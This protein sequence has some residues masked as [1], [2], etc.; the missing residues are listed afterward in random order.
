MPTIED[1]TTPTDVVADPVETPVAP[2]PE[3]EAPAAAPEAST[4]IA[5]ALKVA[6]GKE[7][8]LAAQH[9]SLSAESASLKTKLAA[10]EADNA[11]LKQLVA[12]SS[13]YVATHTSVLAATLGIA[14]DVTAENL[15][16]AIDKKIA[17]GVITDAAQMGIPSASLPA[18]SSEDPPAAEKTRDEFSKLKPEEQM[19]FVKNGGRLI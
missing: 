6:F 11:N 7:D 17:A 16:E 8:P 13:Q 4:R 2:A 9:A 12:A 1:P 10:V 3:V 18:A 5:R 14:G 19:A 15:K